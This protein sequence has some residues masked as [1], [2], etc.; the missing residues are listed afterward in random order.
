MTLPLAATVYMEGLGSLVAGGV[1]PGEG[2]AT[3]EGTG[4]PREALSRGDL[5]SRMPPPAALC[6]LKGDLQQRAPGGGTPRATTLFRP[7]AAPLELG[8]FGVTRGAPAHSAVSSSGLS[9]AW[10]GS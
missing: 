10:W 6:G 2:L 8:G 7:L 4:E 1:G 5:C 3:P 9:W